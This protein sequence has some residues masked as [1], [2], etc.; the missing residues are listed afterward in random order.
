VFRANHLQPVFAGKIPE[1][2]YPLITRICS[3]QE[4]V[5][6]G[7]KER[8]VEKIFGAFANDALVTCSTEDAKNLFD[9]MCDNTK[10]Y[11]TMYDL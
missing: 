5:A 11:L 7:I 8:N 2:I 3:E 10:K 4:L 6:Q 9:E 1:N